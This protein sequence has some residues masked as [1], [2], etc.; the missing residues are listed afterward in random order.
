V[1]IGGDSRGWRAARAT[2]ARAA[3][4][5]AAAERER[6]R[7]EEQK[8]AEARIA[9][10]AAPSPPLPS[11]PKSDKTPAGCWDGMTPG[12]APCLVFAGGEMQKGSRYVARWRNTCA[13]RLHVQ[14]C[15]QRKNGS[16]ECGSDGIAPGAT[17]TWAT[18]EASGEHSGSAIG[19]DKAADDW[20]CSDAYKGWKAH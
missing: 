1:R 7:I 10:A 16:W 9:A 13:R 14:L 19:S 2:A 11:G 17:T 8:Q 20:T 18:Y 6:Q 4:E 5:R 3:A 12:R 15:N